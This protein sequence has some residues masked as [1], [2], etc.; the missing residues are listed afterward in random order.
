MLQVLDHPSSFTDTRNLIS[1]ASALVDVQHYSPDLLQLAASSATARAS[2][3]PSQDLVTLL[4]ALAFFRLSEP[5]FTAAA[6]EALE[7]RG[8]RLLEELG[9][10]HI[11]QL[12][13][14]CVLY[15]VTNGGAPPEALLKVGVR[16]QLS[17]PAYIALRALS[18]IGRTLHEGALLNCTLEVNAHLCCVALSL[19]LSH[20]TASFLRFVSVLSGKW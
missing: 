8:E 1:I 12:W 20:I 14:F 10:R 5:G 2:D 16:N 17:I 6:F 11:A 19:S 18:R 15:H 3:L 13:R 9:P 7:G 4:L